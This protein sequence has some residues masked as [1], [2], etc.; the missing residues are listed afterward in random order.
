MRFVLVIA[1]ALAAWGLWLGEV[2]WVKGWAG[3]EW[4]SGFN[5]S[6]LPICLL[7]VVIS[8]F[9][10][11]TQCAWLGRIKFVGAGSVLTV[12][13]FVAIRSAA[14]EL[15]SGGAPGSPT[16]W[17]AASIV[18]GSVFIVAIGLAVFANLWLVPLHA[19]TGVVVAIGL[20]L[21][22]PLSFMTIAYFPALN[23]STDELHAFKMGYPVFWG[24]MLIPL[25]LEL[26]RRRTKHPAE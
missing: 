25:A 5:W 22:I 8:S 15:F 18:I 26:G 6:A 21:T 23:A 24:A 9:F 4:L 12:G 13:G 11:T 20:F 17:I 7:I 1:G 2:V 3:L 19:W 16:V 14:F 10:L